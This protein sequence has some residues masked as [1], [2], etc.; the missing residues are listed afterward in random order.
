MKKLWKY[1]F[2]YK[3]LFFSRILTI[4]LAALSVICFDFMMGFIVDIFANGET[5]KFVPIILASIFLIMLLF[6]TECLDGYVMSSYVKNTVNYLRCDIFTKILNKD[7]KDFSLDNS[8]K[9]ISILYNDVK[10]IEDNLLNNIFF[11]YLFFYIIYN[12]INIFIFNKSINSNIY[13]YI[14][15]TWIY[16]T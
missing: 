3:L 2:K 1:L 13:S 5:E 6:V 11:N 15:Y 9:Y 10:I 16:N 7:M 8:G 4:S 12:F 14:W